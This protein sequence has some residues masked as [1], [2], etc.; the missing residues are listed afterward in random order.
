[1]R[2]TFYKTYRDLGHF[3]GYLGTQGHLVQLISMLHSLND[4][5]SDIIKHNKLKIMSQGEIS[6]DFSYMWNLK[7]NDTNELTYKTKR[8]SQTSKM[9]L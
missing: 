5:F 1:M 6:Y 2:L 3:K 7:R 9:N 4:S 8:D